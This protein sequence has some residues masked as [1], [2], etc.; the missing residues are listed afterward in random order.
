[1]REPPLP[2]SSH[3]VVVLRLAREATLASFQWLTD[4]PPAVQVASRL[5]ALRLLS[6]P[7][8]SVACAGSPS[9]CLFPSFPGNLAQRSPVAVQ[10]RFLAGERL[11]PLP[12]DVN[13]LRI[14]LDA[15]ADALRQFVGGEW[16][17]RPQVGGV[18]GL[19]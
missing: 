15:V 17:A 18:E 7:V 9:R 5:P 4:P 2:P 1:M 3:A 19:P 8:A 11:P 13:V 16:G 6:A 10:R 12:Y 14:Q